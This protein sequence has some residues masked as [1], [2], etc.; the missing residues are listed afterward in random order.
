MI[1]FIFELGQLKRVKRSGWWLAHVDN[2]ESV[3]DH[4]F[5]AAMIAYLLAMEEG[6]NPEK[7]AVICLLQDI[8]ET[9]LN[10]LHKI[11]HRYIDFRRAEAK[12]FKEQMDTLPKPIADRLTPLFS[13]YHQDGS[14]EGIV[15]RDADLLECA[16]QAKEYIEHGHPECQEW[17]DNTEKLLHT[18]T[19][20]KIL[21]ELRNTAS[22]QWSKGLKKIQR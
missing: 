2:P 19:A 8:P 9:R 21:K 12:V 22:N 14:K 11:G 3:A 6:V 7:A 13:G 18:S 1:D 17:I 15:A 16:V 20:K 4:S 5:R 10:D